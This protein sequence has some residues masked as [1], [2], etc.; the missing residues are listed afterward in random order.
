MKIKGTTILDKIERERVEKRTQPGGSA[1]LCR[2]WQ[3]DG[4]VIE[5]PQTF[6]LEELGSKDVPWEVPPDQAL[7]RGRR[8]P[9]FLRP[10]AR[11]GEEDDV[12]RD[13]G[14]CLRR[15]LEDGIVISPDA[16]PPIPPFVAAAAEAVTGASSL[17]FSTESFNNASRSISGLLNW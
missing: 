1:A 8:W 7:S 6:A 2:R 3:R 12:G 9:G 10:E 17:S 4:D 11:A 15:R 16:A 13:D 14:V 5:K